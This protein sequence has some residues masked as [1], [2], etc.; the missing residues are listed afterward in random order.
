VSSGSPRPKLLSVTDLPR[1][2]SRRKPVDL[3]HSRCDSFAMDW[4]EPWFPLDENGEEAEGL[5]RE[6]AREVSKGHPLHGIPVRGLARRGDC[7]DVLF[8]LD[9]GTGR[10][11]VVH[12]TWT[13]RSSERLPYPHATIYPDLSTWAEQGMR[14]DHAEFFSDG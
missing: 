6:C 2:P 7:D 5:A 4:L 13:S 12:L 11:A 1:V 8:A 3:L 10:V 9:D 14:T